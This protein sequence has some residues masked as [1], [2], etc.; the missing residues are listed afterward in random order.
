[1]N[2]GNLSTAFVWSWS[3]YPEE[4]NESGDRMFFVNQTGVLRYTT[5]ANPGV[6]DTH[7]PA[8]GK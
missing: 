6:Y 8:I 3:A 1:M 4:P 2:S 5:E 7:W